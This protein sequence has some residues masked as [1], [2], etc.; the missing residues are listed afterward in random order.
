MCFDGESWCFSDRFTKRI[1][2]P[3]VPYKSLTG[4]ES[5]EPWLSRLEHEICAA[6]LNKS[7]E[8]IPPE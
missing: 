7:A 5:F 8:E 1:R 3:S 4:I 6:D 2:R